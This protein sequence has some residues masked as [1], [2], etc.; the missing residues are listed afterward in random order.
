MYVCMDDAP[1]GIS[2]RGSIATCLLS[3]QLGPGME[4]AVSIELGTF[5]RVV[6][7]ERQHLPIR[8][9]RFQEYGQG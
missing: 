2:G 6:Q 8:A 9:A 4:N 7:N 3:C 1:I 5:R